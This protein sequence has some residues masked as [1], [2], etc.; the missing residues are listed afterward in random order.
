MCG[1]NAGCRSGAK[2]RTVGP[3]AANG[4]PS[5]GRA[6]VANGWRSRGKRR[7]QDD[8]EH[9]Y[10]DDDDARERRKNP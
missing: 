9:D 2:R 7:R 3:A 6:G 5:S 1:P 10:D 8:N 4:F